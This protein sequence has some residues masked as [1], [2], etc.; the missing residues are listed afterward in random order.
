M[1]RVEVV[2]RRVRAL[3]CFLVLHRSYE[4]DALREREARWTI[5]RRGTVLRENAL[6]IGEGRGVHRREQ[7]Y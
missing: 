4:L 1:R 2:E 3:P 7:A 6:G 5:E